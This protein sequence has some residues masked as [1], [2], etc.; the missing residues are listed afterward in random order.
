VNE[1]PTQGPS[2]RRG[3]P[4][5]RV[6]LGGMLVFGEAQMTLDCTIANLSRSGAR[7]RLA[8]PRMLGEP[9]YL[10]D[11]SHGLAFLAREAWRREAVIGLSFVKYFDLSD[12]PPE[13]PKLL[14]DLWVERQSR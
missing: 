4:R 12:P 8:G 1:P 6:L 2:D 3:G 13:I 11:L 5:R 7:I 9:I 10:I 14:R